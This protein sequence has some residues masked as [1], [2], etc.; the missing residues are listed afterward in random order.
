MHNIQR[1]SFWFV[2]NRISQA[3]SIVGMVAVL[4]YMFV[5]IIDVFLRGAFS[6][7]IVGSMELVETGIVIV[8]FLGL[9]LTEMRGRN[10]CVD[11]LVNRLPQSVQDCVEIATTILALIFFGLMVWQL[12][13]RAFELHRLRETTDVLRMS[14][15]PLQVIVTFGTSLLWLAL[16]AKVMGLVNRMRKSGSS[17]SIAN[18]RST[19]T[20]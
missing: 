7:P 19:A 13:L 17:S 20:E 2:V 9:G 11:L 5:V 18:G 12:G 4:G 16:L 8:I 1:W 15:V 14:K 6:L 10:I 3:S